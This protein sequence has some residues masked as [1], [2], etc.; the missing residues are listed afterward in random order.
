MAFHRDELRRVWRFAAGVSGITVAGVLI[1]QAD[2]LTL[3]KMLPLADYGGYMLAV[4]IAG[5]LYL[6][7]QPFYNVLYPRF[8]LLAHAR[9]ETGLRQTYRLATRLLAA[10]VFPVAMVCGVFARDLVLAWTGDPALAAA[11]AP[12]L[13]LL[14][15]GV[16]LHCVMHVP[17]ALQLAHGLTWIPVVNSLAMLALAVPLTVGLAWTYGAPGGAAAWLALHVLATLLGSWLTHRHLLKGLWAGWIVVD[18][19]VPLAVA[20][21]TGLIA[22]RVVPQA[23]AAPWR[24]AAGLGWALAACALSIALS[25]ALR[26][27]LLQYARDFARRAPQHD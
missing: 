20:L 6:F 19:G 16:A 27:S 13:P 25:P 5:T 2:K 17:Y 21:I 12:L 14:A 9:D 15:A 11:V 22:W 3:S 7:S 4:A 26:A 24:L 10:L 1:T 18:V 23:A 8:S